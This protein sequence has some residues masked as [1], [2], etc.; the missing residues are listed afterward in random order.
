MSQH[1][2][3]VFVAYYIIATS[4][5]IKKHLALHYMI[6]CLK[7]HP[8]SCVGQYFLD[9]QA[10]HDP[11]IVL[12]IFANIYL[13]LQYL[14]FLLGSTFELSKS[15]WYRDEVIPSNQTHDTKFALF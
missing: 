12:R 5:F 9:T 4:I 14:M 1:F 6:F 13:L 11:G 15:W 2:C 7:N 3:D 10:N 8:E